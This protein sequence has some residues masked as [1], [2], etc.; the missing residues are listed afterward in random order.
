[1]SLRAVTLSGVEGEVKKQKIKN[2]II[3]QHL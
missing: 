3:I 1:M 2:E